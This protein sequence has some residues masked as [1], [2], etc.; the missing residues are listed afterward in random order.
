MELHDLLQIWIHGAAHVRFLRGFRRIIAKVRVAGQAISL[1]QRKN[2]FGEIGSERDDAVHLQRNIHAPPSLV[3]ERARGGTVCPRLVLRHARLRRNRDTAG[4]QAH[5][6]AARA[7]GGDP[8]PPEVRARF[9]LGVR[10]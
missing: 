10:R 5:Q 3:G 7:K 6:S 1:I 9:A 2:N 4:Q 8:A